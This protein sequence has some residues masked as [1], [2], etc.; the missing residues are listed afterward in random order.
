MESMK[1]DWCGECV[2]KMICVSRREAGRDRFS[3]DCEPLIGCV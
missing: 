1:I 2:G 3:P